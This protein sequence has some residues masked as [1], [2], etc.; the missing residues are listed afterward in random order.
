[1][2]LTQDNP[3]VLTLSGGVPPYSAR[4]L[5]QTL[6]PIQASKAAMRT[7]NGAMVSLSLPAFE[8]FAS[9]ISSPGDVEP[10][11]GVFPGTVLTVGCIAE[12]CVAGTELPR[13]AVADSIRESGGFTFFRPSLQ[14]MVL[15]YSQQTDE[16]G[17]TTSWTLTLEE[18]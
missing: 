13:T 7:I 3:T 4:G 10:P 9:V 16:Y 6:T 12:L 14:M 11:V 8:K 17:C 5:T 15:D 1:M 18:V 2:T